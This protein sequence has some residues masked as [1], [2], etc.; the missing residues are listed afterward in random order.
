MSFGGVF[1]KAGGGSLGSADE[2]Q[3]LLR[4]AFPTTDVPIE[5]TRTAEQFA[6]LDDS[7]RK[8]YELIGLEPKPTWSW[9]FSVGDNDHGV[10]IE[11][12]DAEVVEEVSLQIYGLGTDSG[13]RVI[14]DAVDALERLAGWTIDMG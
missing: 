14:Q 2:V 9:S 12:D 5:L 4:Q 13:F 10:E 11:F 6:A 8:A 7:I 3:A 1:R